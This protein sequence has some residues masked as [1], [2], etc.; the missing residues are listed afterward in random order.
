[1]PCI[2][3]PTFSTSITRTTQYVLGFISIHVFERSYSVLWVPVF[4]FKKNEEHCAR[5]RDVQSPRLDVRFLSSTYA[6]C[7]C[8]V[9]LYRFLNFICRLSVVTCDALC[10]LAAPLYIYMFIYIYI[11]IYIC[12][13]SYHIILLLLLLFLLLY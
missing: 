9:S 5:R 2:R 8:L 4:L 6:G 3:I 10:I 1:M 12:I 13:L 7:S 11:Y